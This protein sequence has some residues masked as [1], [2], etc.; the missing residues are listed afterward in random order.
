MSAGPLFSASWYRVA[1]LQPR[2]RSHARIHRQ[3]Y[4]GQTWYVLEAR[5]AER[6][7]RFSPAAY[8]VIGLMDGRRTAEQIWDA[9][10]SRLGD[11]G[12]TQDEIIRLLAQLHASDVL[13][14]DVPPNAAEILERYD[15]AERRRWW[16][17]SEERRVGKERRARGW[18][19]G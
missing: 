13:Q 2:L 11:D 5:A 6:F 17:R 12:P 14:C 10:S 15:R 16:S 3:R 19:G 18:C 8:Q 7:H 1:G 9:A 4:R